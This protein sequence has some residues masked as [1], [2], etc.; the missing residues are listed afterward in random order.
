MA[1]TMKEIARASG[2]SQPTVSLV[3]SNKGQRYSE[4]TRR[5]V[6]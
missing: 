6:L 4:S 1:V 5:A 2:V 3:L